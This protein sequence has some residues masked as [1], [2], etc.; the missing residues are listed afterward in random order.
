MTE[1]DHQR[2]LA[3]PATSTTDPEIAPGRSR[4]QDLVAPTHPITSGLIRRKARDDNGV[5][6]GAAQH[7]SAAS[8]GSGSPLPALLQ[9]KFE[10]SL[11]ADLS[12]VRVHTDATSATAADSVG[13]RAYTLGQDIHFGAGHFEPSSSAGEHLL[14]HEVAHTV[15]QHGTTPT[16]QNKLEVSSPGD[17][18]EVEADRAAD[19]MVAGHSAGITSSSISYSRAIFRKSQDVEEIARQEAEKA[20]ITWE[21]QGGQ[22]IGKTQQWLL[23]NWIEY[24]GATSSN[25]HL[26]WADGAIASFCNN[27]AGNLLTELGAGLIRKGSAVAAAEAGLLIGAAG[28]PVGSVVGAVVGFA[29]GTLVEAA[30]GMIFDSI[31]GKTDPDQSAAD[32]S[33]RTAALIEKQR[34]AIGTK[35]AASLADFGGAMDVARQHLANAT[36]NEE[37]MKIRNAASGETKALV[38]H[39]DSDRSLAKKMI[40]DWTLEHAGDTALG[41]GSDTSTAQWQAAA[42]RSFGNDNVLGHP[43]AF[44]YQC[45]GH[46]AQAGLVDPHSDAMIADA[47][48]SRSGSEDAMVTKWAGKFLA[49]N[50]AKD[51]A[52]LAAFLRSN[53]M[54]IDGDAETDLRANQYHL[55]CMLKLAK[56]N[57]AK[58]GYSFGCTVAE[59]NYILTMTNHTGVD[60]GHDEWRREFACTP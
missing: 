55:V 7:V 40:A 36:S 54:P 16:R 57:P 59:W 51:P 2:S 50:T 52:A 48:A 44:A 6:D 26:G 14:A 5:A 53:G 30:A 9:R 21:R 41:A 20:I 17:A 45:R 31:T 12:S 22:A 15:Q 34:A 32:A 29:I 47:L 10:S 58:K 38:G 37:V 19:A 18:L 24:L 4:S 56:M 39:D 60:A 43:E 27:A 3:R 35:S 49:L 1:R 25:P 28:G 23:G 11:G 13:A 46:W 42:Q 8:A 33:T